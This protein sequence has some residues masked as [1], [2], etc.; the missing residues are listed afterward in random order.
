MSRRFDRRWAIALVCG[1]IGAS[2]LAS[3][4]VFQSYRTTQTRIIIEL[5]CLKSV[6]ALFIQDNGY[7]PQSIED[8]I[9]QGYLHRSSSGEVAVGEAAKGRSTEVTSPPGDLTFRHLDKI[10]FGIRDGV[11]SLTADASEP[12]QRTAEAWSSLLRAMIPEPA[13]AATTNGAPAMG[14]RSELIE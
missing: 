6:L 14:Q 11:F 4:V 3:A 10:G 9:G 13:P 5:D 12:V 2:V 8:L 7:P 1:A